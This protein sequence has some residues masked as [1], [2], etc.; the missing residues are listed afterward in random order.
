MHRAHVRVIAAAVAEVGTP[1]PNERS[2]RALAER[3]LPAAIAGG[4]AFVA[5]DRLGLATVLGVRRLL[6]LEDGWLLFVSAALAAGVALTRARALAW[7]LPGIVL[8]IYILVAFTPLTEG[9]VRAWLLREPARPADA[10]VVLSSDVTGEGRLSSGGLA[11]LVAGL[12]LARRGLAPLLVRTDLGASRPD[13]AADVRELAEGTDVE[14]VEVGPVAST[15]DEAVEAARLLRE[16]GLR[17]VIVVTEPLHERRAAATFRALGLE[18]VATPAPERDYSLAGP[19][20]PED[21]VRAFHD[22]ITERAAWTLYSMRGWL[23]EGG[24]ER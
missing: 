8:S 9:A 17:R 13:D 3:T 21:R 19:A 14:I 10:I 12:A 6:D 15:R 22:W 24:E 2:A 18:V 23:S 1:G 11:R 20:R 4:L 7:A 5:A 16:R